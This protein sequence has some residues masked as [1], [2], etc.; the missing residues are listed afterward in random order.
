MNLEEASAHLPLIGLLFAAVLILV[1]L[2]ATVLITTRARLQVG[3]IIE[4]DRSGAMLRN[5]LFGWLHIAL[6]VWI[7][8][9]GVLPLAPALGCIA[10]SMLLVVMTPGGYDAATGETGVLRGWYGRRYAE[11]EEWRLSGVHLRFRLFGEWTSAPLPAREHTRIREKLL[12]ECPERES[13][14]QD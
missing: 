3:E 1:A 14:F 4:Q 10:A 5:G 9:A 6:A 8:A 13:R 11:L 7:L 2:I 12:A